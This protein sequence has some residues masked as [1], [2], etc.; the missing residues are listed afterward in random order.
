ME[1]SVPQV[2]ANCRF[3]EQ[4]THGGGETGQCNRY[5]P[6]VQLTD[7]GQG[8]CLQPATER[9]QWCGEFKVRVDA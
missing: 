2:C 4:D 5:P 1:K 9:L 7:D 6:S 3:W 8:M